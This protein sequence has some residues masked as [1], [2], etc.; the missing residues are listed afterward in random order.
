MA[1]TSKTLEGAAKGFQ[2][3]SAKLHTY[4]TQQTTAVFITFMCDLLHNAQ[5]KQGNLNFSLII[6]LSTHP[7]DNTSWVSATCQVAT[8]N[9]NHLFSLHWIFQLSIRNRHCL[10]QGVIAIWVSRAEAKVCEKSTEYPAPNKEKKITMSS[11]QL[12]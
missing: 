7:F 1:T 5:L 10:R 12:K 2:E 8:K 6:H 3:N 11:S 4:E 9:Q